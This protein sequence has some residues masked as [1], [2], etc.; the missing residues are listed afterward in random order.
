M[1]NDG[2]RHGNSWAS[3]LFWANHFGDLWRFEPSWRLIL[4]SGQGFWGLPVGFFE[5]KWDFMG[6]PAQR[7]A[8]PYLV[9]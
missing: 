5:K 8:L 4:H 3:R 6:E 7:E 2:T 9:F 1:G